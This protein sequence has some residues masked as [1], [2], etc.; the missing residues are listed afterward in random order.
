MI[1]YFSIPGKPWKHISMLLIVLISGM[2]GSAG[3][4]LLKNK[5]T[6]DSIKIEHLSEQLASHYRNR[7][8]DSARITIDSIYHIAEQ[9]GMRRKVADSYYNYSILARAKGNM[10]AFM[11]YLAKSIKIYE[12]EQVL[13]MAARAY[14]AVAQEYVNQKKYQSALEYFS[15]SLAHRTMLE[16]ST[17]MANNMIN[18]GGVC[19]FTG[20]LTDASEYY[21]Q[22]LLIAENLKNI[23]LTA[24]ILQNLGNIHTQLRNYDTALKHLNRALSIQQES[25]NRSEESDVLL[26]LGIAFF[27]SGYTEKAEEY[28]LASLQIKE[29]LEKDLHEMIK[30]YNNL[31][32]VAKELNDNEKAIEYYG[33]TL[34]LSRQ[35]GDKQIE[36]VALN[37]LG[38]RLIEKNNPDAIP[39]ILESLEISTTLG[40]KKLMLSS[41]KNL[42]EYHG[43]NQNFEL[44]Y[45]YAQL[46]QDVNDSLYNEE[47]HARILELQS[48]YELMM[49]DKENELLR[50]AAEIYE[51][52]KQLSQ[53][54][55]SILRLRILFL[56][57]IVIAIAILAFFF[58]VL[59]NMKQ[60]THRQ[61]KELFAKESELASMKLENMEKQNNHLEDMLFAEEEIR[62]LQ[63]NSI[64]QK[65]HELTTSAMLLA[66]KNE[67]FDKLHK[68][69]RQL[70]DSVDEKTAAKVREMLGEIEKQADIEHQWDVF[71]THFESI[72]KTFFDEL[73]RLCGKL[74]QHDLQ[75]CAYIRLNLSNKEISRLMNITHESVN[76]HRYRLR[77]KLGLEAGSLLDE[78]IQSIGT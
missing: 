13:D 58:I 55:E 17:G 62:K 39:L 72:H 27:E 63:Q 42:Q 41:Y 3:N 10:D 31:G 73:R 22:A 60:K 33:I 8:L 47:S 12:E 28:L 24:T 68:L 40:L 57:I 76:T 19:Y 6:N 14:T 61:S 2:P 20:K 15:N 18:L 49:K 43:Y 38:S 45:R 56:V 65:N 32:L 26:N 75:L 48:G 64:D 16:D 78:F 7:K 74:T 34:E 54:K 23:H 52:E 4:D 25:G 77:K 30:V 59:F 37:N 9:A 51:S 46:F 36:A 67:A 53:K 1:K 35:T 11:E 44:A 66:N 70:Y 71:K 21:Y 69:T 29:E 5:F 50:Q